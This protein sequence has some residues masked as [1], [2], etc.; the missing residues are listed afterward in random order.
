LAVA[1][2][3]RRLIVVTR[4]FEVFRELP[5]V[6]RIASLR[7]LDRGG[8]RLIPLTFVDRLE[9]DGVVL[10]HGLTGREEVV[11]EVAAVLWTGRQSARASLFAE[12]KK[13]GMDRTRLIGDAFAPRRLPVALVE[14]HAVA[15][16]I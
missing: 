13:A 14:A 16:H 12:L 4:F 9:G 3:D 11:P 6:S 15:K 1:G 5:M 2:P 10:T 7:E 8:A